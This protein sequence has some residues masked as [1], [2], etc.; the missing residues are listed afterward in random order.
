MNDRTMMDPTAQ[1]LLKQ[2]L[3]QTEEDLKGGLLTADVAVDSLAEFDAYYMSARQSNG[4]RVTGVVFR[5]RIKPH[6]YFMIPGLVVLGAETARILEDR[7]PPAPTPTPK[8]TAVAPASAAPANP[9]SVRAK[10]GAAAAAAVSPLVRAKTRA[11]AKAGRVPP[12]A[13]DP[14]SLLPPPLDGDE[15]VPQG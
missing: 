6:A 7:L 3:K 5:T 2:G 15:R 1:L 8:P 4:D 11:V 12:G 9:A 13:L 10:A 14:G